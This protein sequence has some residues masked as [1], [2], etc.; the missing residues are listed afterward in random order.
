MNA[1][2]DIGNSR[3]KLALFD[4]D[5]IVAEYVAQG[6]DLRP[7]LVCLS[8]RPVEAAILSSVV[9]LPDEIE[10]QL[11]AINVP[12]LHFT[13]STPIPIRNAYHTPETL[14]A[15]R[16]A[17]AVGGWQ[18]CNGKPLLIIDAGS[19]ITFDMVTSDGVY[20]GGN[21]SPGLHARLRAI[22]DYFPRLPLVSDEGDLPELGYDTETA[23]RAGVVQGMRHEI[24]GYIRHFASI[25]KGLHVILTGGDALN[26]TIPNAATLV[27]D[28][29]IVERGLNAI[30]NFN[31]TA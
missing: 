14:G 12:L 13:S 22:D 6:S 2:I 30:L 27:V 8:K 28:Q 7:L 31:T 3:A 5:E 18:R 1:I 21:I 9:D 23:I 29:H 15:D 24:E 19:C 10:E 11:Q 20:V 25:H 4:G 26:L 17:A 16:L